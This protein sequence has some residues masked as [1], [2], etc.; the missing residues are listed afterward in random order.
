[1]FIISGKKGV[2]SGASGLRIAYLSGIEQEHAA[3]QEPHNFTKAE[4]DALGMP[5]VSD[6]KFHGV[7]ILMTSQWPLGV[8]KYAS[9]PVS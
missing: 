3:V 7:D 2:L 6:S 1:M 5:L 4:V 9:P 8:A